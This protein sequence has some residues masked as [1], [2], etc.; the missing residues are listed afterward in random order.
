VKILAVDDFQT[1]DVNDL[2]NTPV[3]SKKDETDINELLSEFDKELMSFKPR[4][5]RLTWPEPIGDR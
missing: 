5:K 1:A 2:M 4:K 3:E